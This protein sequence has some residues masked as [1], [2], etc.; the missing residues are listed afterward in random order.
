MMEPRAEEIADWL[1]ERIDTP[2]AIRKEEQGDVDKVLMTL[3]KVTYLPGDPRRDDYVEEDRIVLS[4]EG[5]IQ[6]EEG[7]AELPRD[8]YEIPLRSG[9]Q[10]LAQGQQLRV[11]TDRA[12]YLVTPQ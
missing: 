4:G 8:S 5:Q 1:A 6:A 3:R 7:A 10:Y 11:T 9:F 2:L 12:A